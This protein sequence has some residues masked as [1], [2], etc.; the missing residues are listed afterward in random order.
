MTPRMV[1]L[2]VL[3]AVHT[4]MQVVAALLVFPLAFVL[5]RHDAQK[6]DVFVGLLPVLATVGFAKLAV[7]RVAPVSLE[8]PR[9]LVLVALAAATDFALTY[10]LGPLVAH[11]HQDRGWWIIALSLASLQAVVALQMLLAVRRGRV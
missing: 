10:Y 1:P 11:R 9:L 5:S 4:A 2:P 3:A 7:R 6:L 8:W